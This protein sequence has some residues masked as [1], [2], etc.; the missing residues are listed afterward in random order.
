[1]SHA[2]QALLVGT[3]A[4]AG[5]RDLGERVLMDDEAPIRVYDVSG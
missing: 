1:M 4:D 3:L 2:T 5:L